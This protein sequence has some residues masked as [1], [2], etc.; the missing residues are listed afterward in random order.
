[1]IK[2]QISYKLVIGTCT[3]IESVHAILKFSTEA[4]P[5]CDIKNKDPEG[6]YIKAVAP[7]YLNNERI[8]EKEGY[9]V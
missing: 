5:E 3:S 1:M 7:F 9:R 6:F 4:P 2:E 8:T